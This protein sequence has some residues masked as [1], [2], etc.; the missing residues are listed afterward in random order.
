M[1]HLTTLNKAL[2]RPGRTKQGS[3]RFEGV[4]DPKIP[5]GHL[6][7]LQTEEEKQNT[8][9]T[10][11]SVYICLKTERDHNY[12]LFGPELTTWL[13]YASSTY[14]T[15]TH[16][17]VFVHCTSSARAVLS[18]QEEVQHGSPLPWTSVQLYA[19]KSVKS[20]LQVTDAA[21]IKTERRLPLLVS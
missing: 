5:K 19:V 11:I 3:D 10:H 16:H 18:R 6:M 2:I 1:M 8:T 12:I 15:S 21:R 17:F 7:Q 20:L 9:Q 14:G 13:L 4:S